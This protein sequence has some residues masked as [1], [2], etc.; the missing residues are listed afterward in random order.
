[1]GSFVKRIAQQQLELTEHVGHFQRE[2]SAAVLALAEEQKRL[3][4]AHT[5][6]EEAHAR[7]EEAH[8]RLEEAQRHTEERLNA[9]IS[10]VDGIVRQPPQP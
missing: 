3:A 2:I 9:L 8:A 4:E 7:M 1:M 10:V 5:R 6:L